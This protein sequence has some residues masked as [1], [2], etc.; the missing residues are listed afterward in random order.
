[1]SYSEQ[2]ANEI[3]TKI[4]NVLIDLAI[5]DKLPLD[6]TMLDESLFVPIIIN[7]NGNTEKEIVISKIQ[8]I[9]ILWGEFGIGEVDGED[10]S[11]CVSS[12]GNF[13][14]LAEHFN[15]TGVS[16]FVYNPSSHSSDPIDD[17]N[18]E[19]DELELD[20]LKEILMI[21]ERYDAQEQKLFDS[22]KDENY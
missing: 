15:N 6:M 9:L 2:T 19:Y 7:D 1:M 10:I 16:V 3:A 14:D 22:F 12:Q 13:T 5:N 21:A 11:P 20:V 4:K 17:Y 8:D 18:L